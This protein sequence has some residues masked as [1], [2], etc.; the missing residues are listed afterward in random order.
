MISGFL[1]HKTDDL[2]ARLKKLYR[3]FFG[4]V[5]GRHFLLVGRLI[6]FKNNKGESTLG[7]SVREVIVL[8]PLGRAIKLAKKV[9]QMVST[10]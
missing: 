9:D 1:V 7:N 3:T 8:V 4:M 6:V 2:L 10:H 5:W